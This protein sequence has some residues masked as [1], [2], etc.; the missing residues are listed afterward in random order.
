MTKS[1]RQSGIGI[2]DSG[3]GGLTTL[4]YLKELLPEERLIY[5]GD[6]A[7]TPY[8]SKSPRTIREFS[9]QITRFLLSQDIKALLIACNTASAVA[10]DSLRE[11]FPD[12][13]IFGIIRP[14]IEAIDRLA[15]PGER[16][17]VLGTKRTI[18]SGLYQTEL[19]KV[20]P[21]LEL[22]AVACP[23]WVN[24]VEE[25]I[26]KGPFLEHALRYY[27][28]EE[29]ARDFDSM[30]LGCTHY[31]ILRPELERLYPSLKF[32]DPAAFQVPQ[33]HDYLKA[34]DLL[35]EKR[36]R[37]DLFYASD[38]SENFHRMIETL[39]PGTDAVTRFRDLSIDG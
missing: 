12:L 4:P 5:F 34:H 26:T 37:E 15:V 21:D 39:I 13:P 19:K 9:R 35:A 29:T 20:R 6:T 22:T 30:L 3:L 7:R 2:F 8:G 14:T 18:N 16:L 11:A 10:L 32:Y 25:G 27:L 28:P 24:L 23:L 17:L 33:L 38:L 36:E 1:N 31:P